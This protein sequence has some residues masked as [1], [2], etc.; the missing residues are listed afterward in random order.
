MTKGPI[1][2]WMMLSLILTACGAEAIPTQAADPQAMIAQPTTAVTKTDL[3]TDTPTATNTWVPSSTPTIGPPPDLELVNPIAYPEHKNAVG[4]D[5]Y[6]LG[7]IRN[8]TDQIMVFFG[9]DIVFKFT[10]ET[11]QR[12]TD[13]TGYFYHSKY[14]DEAIRGG[15]SSRSMN[16]ILYPG[17]EGV[18]YYLARSHRGP[19]GYM[20]W[21]EIETYG[22]SL[23]LSILSYESYYR[24]NPELPPNLHL[25][26]ENITYQKVNGGLDFEFNVLNIPQKMGSSY[27]FTSIYTWVIL[28]D[29]QERIIN[30]LIRDLATIPG[31]KRGEN[32]H[33]HG[34]TTAGYTDKEKYFRPV[35]DITSDIIESVTRI[36]VLTEYTE[37]NMC[38]ILSLEN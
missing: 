11:W 3:M 28:Y 19:E 14:I 17:D 9:K 23:G 18:Y 26:I 16:C 30:I 6:I 24:T 10:L 29:S 36:E 13:G 7:R 32:F 2:L 33:V 1:V 25:A 15:E 31:I 20:L 38:S 8:N 12:N 37:G 21:E 35:R 5:Y 4:D 27:D 22:G 34:N